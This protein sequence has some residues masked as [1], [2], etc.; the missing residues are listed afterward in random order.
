[1]IHALLHAAVQNINHSAPGSLDRA[2]MLLLKVTALELC[3]CQTIHM[4]K[5][6]SMTLATANCGIMSTPMTAGHMICMTNLTSMAFRRAS[7]KRA[8][9]ALTQN[10]I[11]MTSMRNTPAQSIQVS[12]SHTG[13]RWLLSPDA[14]AAPE[15]ECSFPVSLGGL[16]TNL[17]A[18]RSRCTR[19]LPG[20]FGG[21]A[22]R[23]CPS[24]L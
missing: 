16:L 17:F 6:I 19:G 1:M 13:H 2:C 9:T 12:A 18:V 4:G 3:R 15:A 21:R 22:G 20:R 7:P 11:V 10:S 24:A 8:A 23:R 14:E 5:L